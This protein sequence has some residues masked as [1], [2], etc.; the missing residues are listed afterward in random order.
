MEK[1]RKHLLSLFRV[2]TLKRQIILLTVFS[3]VF[4]FGCSDNG[5]RPNEQIVLLESNLSNK[6]S[7]LI[8]LDNNFSNV[9]TKKINTNGLMTLKSFEEDLFILGP[10]NS[11][12]VKVIEEEIDISN[13]QLPHP[14]YIT[15]FKNEKLMVYNYDSKKD[16]NYYTYKKEGETEKDALRLK[17][18]PFAVLSNQNYLYIYSRDLTELPENQFS[19][20][21][22]DSLDYR[23]V[24]EVKIKGPLISSSLFVDDNKLYI[25]LADIE[26]GDSFVYI[27]NLDNWE[28]EYR[29]LPEKNVV[30]LYK[31]DNYMYA[32]NSL[33][34][35]T[36][37]T[38]YNS[39]FSEAIESTRLNHNIEKPKFMNSDLYYIYENEEVA[40]F[41]SFNLEDFKIEKEIA[42]SNLITDYV[43]I[44]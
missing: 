13:S 9:K 37:I 18:I 41:Y 26:K 33:I 15:S 20:N 23:V 30:G 3:L 19:L 34:E 31:K 36:L 24:R 38:K 11:E 42:I 16:M 43:I 32:I 8:Y 10:Y 22:I 12:I 21:I 25:S 28:E 44:E 1:K 39:D 29:K 5:K 7:K 27:L 4:I 40:S 6:E 35:E 14:L 2:S 17:G